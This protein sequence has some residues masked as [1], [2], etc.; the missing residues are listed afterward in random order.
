MVNALGSMLFLLLAD[1]PLS[2][3]KLSDN[4]NQLAPHLPKLN[5][6]L[7]FC[8]EQWLQRGWLQLTADG[9]YLLSDDI[10]VTQ[11]L[12]RGVVQQLP[13]AKQRVS[14][15][16]LVKRIW[17]NLNGQDVITVAFYQVLHQHQHEQFQ[18]PFCPE[19][20]PRLLAVLQG[21]SVAAPAKPVA[22]KFALSFVVNEDYVAIFTD[23]VGYQITDESYAL[24]MLATLLLRLSYADAGMLLSAHAAAVGKAGTQILLPANSGSGKSTLTA[25]LLAQGWE[26][27][28]DDVV[29]LA[30]I[31]EQTMQT[32]PFRTAVGLKP[33][34]W[35]LL[36]GHYPIIPSLAV[37]EYAGKQ[38]KFLPLSQS[39]TSSWK[40][41]R[42]AAV[43]FPRFSLVS[44]PSLRPLALRETIAMFL[45]SGV[46]FM[47]HSS[48]KTANLTQWLAW[49]QHAPCYEM[50]FNNSASVQQMLETLL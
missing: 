17:V 5:S 48:D 27:Y 13:T 24:S 26:Y 23:N 16:Q 7:T 50:V 40:T 14:N 49:L 18:Q 10:T 19:A 38:A 32:L 20:I 45:V 35:P 30:A 39:A 4:V 37:T 12:P 34:S 8:L 44:T 3:A 1:Q 43:V 15:A 28:G 6:H 22:E 42:I 29:A 11:S 2:F 36:T 21:V 9:R 25:E 46:S 33:G 41:G 47:Q 31:G